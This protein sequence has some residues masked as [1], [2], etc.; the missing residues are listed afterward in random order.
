M[1]KSK[2]YRLGR[3]VLAGP[4]GR[5]QSFHDRKLDRH[6]MAIDGPVQ[7]HRH[8]GSFAKAE[9]EFEQS[10]NLKKKDIYKG[11][12]VFVVLWLLD[13][14][15]IEGNSMARHWNFHLK[16]A[17]RGKDIPFQFRRSF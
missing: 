14:Q 8:F 17:P 7:C 15:P 16:T 6:S 3:P 2:S 12:C 1:R 5:T 10:P 9:K 11:K 13:G 4:V